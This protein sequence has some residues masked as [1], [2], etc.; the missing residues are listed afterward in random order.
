MGTYVEQEKIENEI[1]NKVKKC[2]NQE[3]ITATN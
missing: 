2:F 3:R 1:Q